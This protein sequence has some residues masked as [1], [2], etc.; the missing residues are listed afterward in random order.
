MSTGDIWSVVG[1]VAAIV[2]IIGGIVAR[3]RQIHSTIDGVRK[4]AESE[5]KNLHERIN[6]THENMV[7]QTDLQSLTSRIEVM[8]ASMQ[9]QLNTIV[10]TL[11]KNKE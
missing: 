7:R 10:S 3:D 5:H 8:L 4:E 2:A 9:G 11:L 1:A 6:H